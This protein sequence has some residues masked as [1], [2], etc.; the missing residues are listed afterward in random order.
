MRRIQSNFSHCWRTFQ[1]VSTDLGNVIKLEG[2]AKHS[3]QA[4]WD[5]YAFAS[6]G[7]V[8][9][10]QKDIFDEALCVAVVRMKKA[11]DENDRSV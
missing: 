8:E 4:Y 2:T 9:V 7:R 3:E 5:S 6:A 1:D 10:H 11:E